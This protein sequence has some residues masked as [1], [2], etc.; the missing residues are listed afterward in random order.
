MT[1]RL[2]HLFGGILAT[3]VALALT[4]APRVTTAAA[5]PEQE[6]AERYAPIV[7]VQQHTEACGAGEPYSPAP[8]EVVLGNDDVVL[9][10]NG[11]TI[12]TTAPTAD[13]LAAAPADAYL[14]FPGNA[15]EPRCDYERWFDSTGAR[16][17][18]TVYARVATDPD[19]PGR[20]ALQYWVFWV[21]NDWND[22]HE[23]DWE[24]LQIAF[25]ADDA[26][27]A[28]DTDPVEVAVA[29]HEGSE[30]RA[31][32]RVEK[33]DDHPVVYP[34]TGSHATYY[35]PNRWFGKSAASGFGCD[36]TRGPSASI[37]PTVV[38]LPD[39]TPTAGDPFAW[40]TFE[41]RWGERQPSFNNGP[42]GPITKDQWAH[43]IVWMEEEGRDGSVSLP[44]LGTK[45]TDFFCTASAT[46]SILFIN[47]LDE[48][49]LVAIAIVA[50][51]ALVVVGVKRTL[52]SPDEPLPLVARRRNGQIMRGA[53]RLLF[54]HR[55]RFLP[56]MLLVLAGGLVAAVVQVVVLRIP[57]FDDVTDIVGR[58]QS[59]GAAV[60]LLAGALVSIPVG[61]YAHAATLR[62]ASDIDA[63][64]EEGHVLRRT[65]GDRAF[66]VAA[67][68]FLLFSVLFLVPLLA[69]IAAVLWCVA[70]S[71]AH[72][73]GTGVVAS[74]RTSRRL[75]KGNR[76]RTLALVVAVFGVTA[77]TGPF[78]G[79]LVLILTNSS[80]GVVNL[81]AA[82]F[83]AVLLPWMALCLRLLHGELVAAAV[84]PAAAS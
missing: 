29:Q 12:I 28:L 39:G 2:A 27:A 19:E 26:T 47:F 40:L 45:V 60:A 22:R 17:T 15:L 56:I 9:R 8:V 62:L 37:E 73:D 32:D 67:A 14:D 84:S 58:D 41:G 34:G 48:P 57:A 65:R 69:A 54:E 10:A 74:F 71:A 80:F 52:W 20:L 76:W 31:W 33:V 36:D 49:W 11:G 51:I 83:F 78:V 81:I 53:A 75:G 1:S 68:F 66:M 3:S 59:I 44:P 5:T 63:G 77:F 55:R 25:D 21:Y 24:M 70:S 64:S 72:V 50:V 6:L 42:T 7:R 46:G 82:L 18:P 79:T 23:G 43:P 38:M 30:R 35:T 16:N 61:L 13:D 4:V